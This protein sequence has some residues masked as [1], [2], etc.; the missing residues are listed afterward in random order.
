[1]EVKGG[2]AAS[3]LA[4][5]LCVPVFFAYFDRSWKQGTFRP[6]LV[7]C[8]VIFGIDAVFRGGG[9]GVSQIWPPPKS[10]EVVRE[11]GAK[12]LLLRTR[13]PLAGQNP[14]RK[15]GF[16]SKNSHLPVPQKRALVSG[17]TRKMGIF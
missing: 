5:A 7:T 12:G 6:P 13:P 3:H 10:P 4:R 15:E 11:E 14:Q 1:M 9:V 17:S 8:R 16:G 2:R